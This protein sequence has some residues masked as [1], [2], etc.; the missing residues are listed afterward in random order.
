[1][2]FDPARLGNSGPAY[3]TACAEGRAALVG[4]LPV[5]YPGVAITA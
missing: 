4:Y 5:G 1:M 2:T 3:A